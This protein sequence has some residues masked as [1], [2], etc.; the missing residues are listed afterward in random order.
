[1]MNALVD[2]ESMQF[3]YRVTDPLSIGVVREASSSRKYQRY[4]SITQQSKEYTYRATCVTRTRANRVYRLSRNLTGFESSGRFA[5]KLS[6]AR[7]RARNSPGGRN[8]FIKIQFI[9]DYNDPRRVCTD[10]RAPTR[11][12]VAADRDYLEEP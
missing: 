2:T 7:E 4:L 3:P 6:V 1:M 8:S 9:R 11:A 5:A 12:A 10:A